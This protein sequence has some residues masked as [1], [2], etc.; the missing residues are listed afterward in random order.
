MY[1]DVEDKA[2]WDGDNELATYMSGLLDYAS[3]ILSKVKPIN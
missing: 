2:L 1:Q 3:T